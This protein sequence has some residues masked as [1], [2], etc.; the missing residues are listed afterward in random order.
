MSY[1]VIQSGMS[2]IDDEIR[3]KTDAFV[4]D[5]IV[6]IRRAALESVSAALG[7]GWGGSGWGGSGP[8]AASVEGAVKRG[9]G[10][11]KKIASAAP[12]AKAPTKAAPPAKP[13]PSPKGKPAPRKTVAANRPLGAKRPPAE[14]ARLT[15]RLGEYIK[16][17]P[18]LRIEP[19]GVALGEPTKD[20]SL[21]IK[22]LL[23]AKKIRSVGH[24]RA[25][26][27]FAA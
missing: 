13:A 23:A 24:K 16:S 2:N 17:H 19:I 9:R 5:L 11:P 3:A 20:L 4:A 26:E 15:E 22:K 8:V 7:S 27:Y 1:R 10:R 21:P 14:L 25:T 12:I 6:L 18:G